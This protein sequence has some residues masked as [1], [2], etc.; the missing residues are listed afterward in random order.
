VINNKKTI[1]IIGCGISG[2]SSAIN[3]I[4]KGYKVRIIEQKKTVGGRAGSISNKYGNIDI[5]QHIFLDSYKN[6]FKLI[7]KLDL[8][9]DITK[10]ENL[11][12]PIVDNKKKYYIKSNFPIYPFSIIF[13]VLGYKNIRLVERIRVLYGLIKIRFINKKRKSVPFLYWLKQ[14]HQSN[15]SIVKFWEIICKPAFNLKLE[16][17][18]NHQAY[19]LF[20]Y[21]IFGPKKNISICYSKKPFSALFTKPF[22]KFLKDNNSEIIFSEKIQKITNDSQE[23]KIMSENHL[24]SAEKV[25]IATD[26]ENSLKLVNL[27]KNKIIIQNSSIINIIFWFDKKIIEDDFTA[28]S[29]SE[30][31]WIFSEDEKKSGKFSQKIT[32]SL[33][34]TDH[35]LGITNSDLIRNFENMIRKELSVKSNTKLLRSLI[36]RSPKATQRTKDTKS[37]I[38]YGKNIFFVGDWLI[39]NLPNTMEAASLSSKLLV[40]EKF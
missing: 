21:M 2:I 40:E 32:I 35:L 1:T 36:I 28:F 23:I 31:Q 13:A 26:L 5:G 16:N 10:N 18:S 6:F 22:E 4:E 34:D 12:I 19:D 24:Y 30:L 39:D 29:N 7:S 38:N 9:K 3:L 14:N 25:I 17:F 8:E 27:S 20:K 37:I 15:E 33:S 11:R